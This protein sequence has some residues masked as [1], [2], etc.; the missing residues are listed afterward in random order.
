MN[1]RRN[2]QHPEEVCIY[3][4]RDAAGICRFVGAG[5]RGTLYYRANCIRK[6]HVDTYGDSPFKQWLLAERAAGRRVEVVSTKLFS[7]ESLGIRVLKRDGSRITYEKGSRRPID[8]AIANYIAGMPRH[9]QEGLLNGRAGVGKRR[10][11]DALVAVQGEVVVGAG[12]RTARRVERKSGVFDARNGS[13]VVYG[14][15]HNGKLLY[16]GTTAYDKAR[17]LQALAQPGSNSKIRAYVRGLRDS[18]RLGELS[19]RKLGKYAP[20]ERMTELAKVV[21]Y[22]ISDEEREG[23]LN[24]RLGKT[25]A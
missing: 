16:V 12:W 17:T 25:G 7:P 22:G 24:E 13:G 10:K 11:S 19:M 15:Y 1:T 8:S 9:V 20:G 5:R 14:L 3:E 21:A 2:I 23:L 6:G 4:V 18:Q